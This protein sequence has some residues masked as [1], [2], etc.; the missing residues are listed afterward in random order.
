[1][2]LICCWNCSRVY[3][4][5]SFS[6]QQRKCFKPTKR[7]LTCWNA[8][9]VCCDA[10]EEKGSSTQNASSVPSSLLETIGMDELREELR[11]SL[12]NAIRKAKDKGEFKLTEEERRV[13]DELE[14]RGVEELRNIFEKLKEQMREV[15]NNEEQ[16]QI[17]NETTVRR[18]RM[19]D[20]YDQQV[21]TL[22]QVMQ[23]ERKKLHQEK[24]QIEQL[25]KQYEEDLQRREA[26]R[27]N[28]LPKVLLLACGVTFGFSCLYYV[29]VSLETDQS[30]N[31]RNAVWNALATVVAVLVYESQTKK[32]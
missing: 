18:E 22:L 7:K 20:L 25:R 29:W 26:I 1:M 15:P 4:S 12:E 28:T 21:N 6:P 32:K 9:V 5:K 30:D 17:E 8:E 31:L 14:K 11:S 24:T 3:S 16:K 19:L 13:L 2:F 10:V 23:Q 27:P